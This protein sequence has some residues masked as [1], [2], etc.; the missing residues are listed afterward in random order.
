MRAVLK[1]NPLNNGVESC[2]REESS[3]E[4][5]SPLVNEKSKPREC[6]HNKADMKPNECLRKADMI[7]LKNKPPNKDIKF[8]LYQ[9][10][11]GAHF[12]VEV[13]KHCKKKAL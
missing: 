2:W 12:P 6:F 8:H 1:L 3:E 11:S 5:A 9:G 13:C 7:Y 4:D 10:C